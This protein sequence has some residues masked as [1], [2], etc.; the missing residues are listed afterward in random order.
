MKTR[1]TAIACMVSFAFLLAVPSALAQAD[2]LIG[3]WKYTEFVS[4][5]PD[6]TST[7]AQPG[8]LIFT[9]KYWSMIMVSGDKPRPAL[10][11]NATD[12]QKLGAW[13][14]FDAGSGTYEVKGNTYTAKSI[15]GKDPGIDPDSFIVIEFKIEGN[16]LTTTPKATN[17]GPIDWGGYAKLT[18]L[19]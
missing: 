14:P 7:P 13:T 19:E 2:K 17:A 10:P 16:T 5:G 1:I 12:A 6:A 8:L 9:K 3:V 15:V 4:T 11:Q 18:R